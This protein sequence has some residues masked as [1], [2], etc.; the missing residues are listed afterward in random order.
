MKVKFVDFPKSYLKIKDKVLP[1]IDRVLSEGKLILQEDVEKFEENLAKYVGTKYAVGVNSGT[2]ALFLSLKA[3][4]IGERDEVITSGYT[5]WATV[6]AIINCGA[7]PVIADIGEDLL[8]DV[9]DVKNKI[10][11]KT[12]A[13]IPVH[14]G[15]AVC[16]MDEIT[17]I[18][19]EHNLFIVEDCAQAL[20]GFA[21]SGLKVGSIGNTGC[22]SFYPAKVL[23]CYGDGGAITTNDEKL[24]DKLILL[25]NHGG[26]PHPQ[27]VGYNSRL[28]NL[29]AVIL[30][31]RLEMIEEL[32]NRRN[33]IADI[34]NIELSNLQD[35]MVY[36]PKSQTYQEYNIVVRDKRNRLYDF[37]KENGV[38][39]IK[40]DYGFP[41]AQP[42]KTIIANDSVLRLPV[43]P[44]LTDEEIKYVCEIIKK[45][46]EKV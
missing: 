4:G 39:T 42:N 35:G 14:I 30:N 11:K 1:E 8:I 5:F 43:W 20:G 12:K 10:T 23:G 25:R 37:L 7:T 2:D 17:G 24:H 19:K 13:I 28:D 18:A 27:L 36:L 6:E 44:D 34:Y 22:F 16:D 33:E 26:K 46:Y 3:L 41:T 31:I 38:E 45:F 40:G 15:G 29:Q 21:K 9:E 32:I